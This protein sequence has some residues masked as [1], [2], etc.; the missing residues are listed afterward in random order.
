[1]LIKEKLLPLNRGRYEHLRKIH[2]AIK[3][4]QVSYIEA[5]MQNL[6]TQQSES[7]FE[8]KKGFTAR[9]AYS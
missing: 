7:K 9:E 8:K 6:T 5:F 3:T 4:E 2:Q 1:M